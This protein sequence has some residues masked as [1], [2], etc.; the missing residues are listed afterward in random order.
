MTNGG[1]IPKYMSAVCRHCMEREPSVPKLLRREGINFYLENIKYRHLFE[2][3]G[4]FL[5]MSIFGV[6]NWVSFLLCQNLYADI[7]GLLSRPNE[8]Y[9]TVLHP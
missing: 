4:F 6:K 5:K 8:E 1:F 3:T 9:G 7:F 2:A